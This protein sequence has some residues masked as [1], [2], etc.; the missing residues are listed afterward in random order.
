MLSASQRNF[1][2]VR[3]LKVSD[4]TIGTLCTEGNMNTFVEAEL[5]GLIKISRI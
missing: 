3:D 2:I 4:R 1:V 5:I